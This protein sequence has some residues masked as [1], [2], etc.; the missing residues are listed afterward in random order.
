LLRQKAAL[1]RKLDEERLL[2]PFPPL[3]ETLRQLSR[4]HSRLTMAAAVRLTGANRYTI[5]LHLRRLV[6]GGHLIQ[7]GVGRGSWCAAR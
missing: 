2:A 6:A 3:T 5:K 1:A 4:E 7:G